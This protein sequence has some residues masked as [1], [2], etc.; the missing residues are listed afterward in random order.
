MSIQLAAYFE[1][2]PTKGAALFI[3]TLVVNILF[4]ALLVE[5][6]LVIARKLSDFVGAIKI[7]QGIVLL[8]ASMFL[9]EVEFIK[10]MQVILTLL[11]KS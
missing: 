2:L 3:T 4:E 7:V 9:V 6:V 8:T 11:I 5:N 1:R 10:H